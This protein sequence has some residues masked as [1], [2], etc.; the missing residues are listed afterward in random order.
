MAEYFVTDDQWSTGLIDASYCCI[1]AYAM[2]CP[3]IIVEKLM[4]RFVPE[5]HRSKQTTYCCSILSCLPTAYA[6]KEVGEY[7]LDANGETELM[8]SSLCCV[9]AASW[10]CFIPISYELRRAAC[11]Y[12]GYSESVPKSMFI[13]LC[14]WPCSIRQVKEEV[15]MEDVQKGI[16]M[17]NRMA[18]D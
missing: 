18:F 2:C 13:S 8:Y 1:D 6:T 17:A 4:H 10:F 7:I 5:R 12:F 14:L 3:C 9:Y 16:I 15:E 11:K